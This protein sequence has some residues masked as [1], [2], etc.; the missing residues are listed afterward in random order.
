M[1]SNKL[2]CILTCINCINKINYIIDIISIINVKNDIKIYNI[3]KI[4]SLKIVDLPIF[5]MWSHKGES[6][7]K[8]IHI[9]VV[10]SILISIMYII[11]NSL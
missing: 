4:W 11:L 7:L 9:I 2:I 1:K 6:L 10:I 5:Y 8:I 3:Y